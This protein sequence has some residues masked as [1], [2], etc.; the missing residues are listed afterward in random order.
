[1]KVDP[2]KS[3]GSV[4]QLK[5]NRKLVVSNIT[6]LY[7]TSLIWQIWTLSNYMRILR[8][9]YSMQVSRNTNIKIMLPWRFLAKP[10][11]D[12]SLI[13]AC[14]LINFI[15]MW[16]FFL[17][18]VWSSYLFDVQDEMKWI[19]HLGPFYSKIY[20]FSEVLCRIL[21]SEEQVYT[22]HHTNVCSVKFFFEPSVCSFINFIGIWMFAI[23]WSKV[24]I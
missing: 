8:S 16:M 12:C 6:C 11:Q 5:S 1:M 24:V 18:G 21:F 4:W 10:F 17:Y 15:R 7:Q 20:L 22:N 2:I 14:C 9:F 13:S 3:Y 23:N 19:F